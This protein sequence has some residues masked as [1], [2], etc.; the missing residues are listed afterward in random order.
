MYCDEC[1]RYYSKKHIK[2]HKCKGAYKTVS[3]LAAKKMQSALEEWAEAQKGL[4]SDK[5]ES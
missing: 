3:E 1:K 5:Q 2:T 4:K